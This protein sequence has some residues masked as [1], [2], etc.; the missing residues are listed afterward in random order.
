MYRQAAGVDFNSG[1]PGPNSHAGHAAGVDLNSGPPGP[2][3]HAGHAAGVDLNSGP[4]GPTA[5]QAMCTAVH[6]FV[7]TVPHKQANKQS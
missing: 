4:P 3:S 5:M 2:N 6:W 1:P 7:P